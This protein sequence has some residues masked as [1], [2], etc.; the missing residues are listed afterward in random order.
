MSDKESVAN[1]V[2]SAMWRSRGGPP[3]GNCLGCLAQDAANLQAAMGK[4]SSPGWV[5][6]VERDAIEFSL[7]V[8]I[9][10]GNIEKAEVEGNLG[11]SHSYFRC[12]THQA[13]INRRRAGEE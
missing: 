10:L 5:G 9:L 4:P 3:Y 11:K 8:G 12:H 2:L 13:E 1:F 7:Q 6:E